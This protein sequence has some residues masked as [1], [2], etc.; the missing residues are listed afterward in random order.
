M[1]ARKT[2]LHVTAWTLDSADFLGLFQALDF[3]IEPTLQDGRGGASASAFNQMTKRRSRH[4][5][6]IL[7][8]GSG[9]RTTNLDVTLFTVGATAMLGQLKSGSL[10][11]LNNHGDGSGLADKDEFPNAMDCSIEVQA[12]FL[13][14]S[15]DSAIALMADANNDTLSNRNKTVSITVGGIAY[16]VPMILGTAKHSAKRSD[17]QMLDITLSSR[18]AAT[19][20]TGSNLYVSTVTGDALITVAATTGAGAYAG[21]GLISSLDVSLQDGQIVSNSGVIDMQGKWTIS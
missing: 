2:S 18:G 20:P 16:V 10:R 19:G 9:Q 14:P 5:F 7:Q 12:S 21:T 15:A 11:I 8:D 4:A 1:S 6:E 13:I 17:F 3:E